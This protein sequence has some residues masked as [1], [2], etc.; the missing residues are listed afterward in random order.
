ML[1][2]LPS[3]PEHL[4]PRRG[5]L[6]F[7]SAW[8]AGGG[9]YWGTAGHCGPGQVGEVRE[10]SLPR[11]KRRSGTMS[12]PVHRGVRPYG[13]QR[14]SF[15][16]GVSS[17]VP[18][19]PATRPPWPASSTGHHLP[20]QGSPLW[21]GDVTR[22][23]GK[24]MSRGFQ[25]LLRQTRDCCFEGPAP[26]SQPLKVMPSEAPHSAQ[27]HLREEGSEARA[28]VG[29]MFTPPHLGGRHR[30]HPVSSQIFPSAALSGE[31][32]EGRSR[33]RRG[34]AGGGPGALYSSS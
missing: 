30:A 25:Q 14:C 33:V 8:A 11:A 26:Q 12:W 32:G 15:L 34:R 31:D 3:C 13:P 21:P 18:P 2:S 29:L 16:H 5:R 24:T 1:L 19:S 9:P 10:G 22:G 7:V 23:P 20:D 4:G 17:E 28:G 27:I 6:M